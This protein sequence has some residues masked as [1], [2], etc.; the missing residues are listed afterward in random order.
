[1][2]NYVDFIACFALVYGIVIVFVC[3][4]LGFV[5]HDVHIVRLILVLCWNK[6]RKIKIGRFDKKI[7]I[8]Q[9]YYSLKKWRIITKI[10]KNSSQNLSLFLFCRTHFC[11]WKDWNK[12]T[13]Q[14]TASHWALNKSPHTQIFGP[15]FMQAC[16][17]IF[18]LKEAPTY[19]NPVYGNT[20]IFLQI[21][22]YLWHNF[23][24]A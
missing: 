17:K 11:S 7:V 18:S 3:L 24:D 6:E 9:R 20:T 22:L 12:R 23:Y 10:S 15:D 19:E 4:W 16:V 21:F 1:M 5:I 14:I 2:V 13:E 8:I